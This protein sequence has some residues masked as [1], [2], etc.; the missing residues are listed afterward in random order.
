MAVIK[1]SKLIQTSPVLLPPTNL[2]DVRQMFSDNHTTLELYALG[3][4]GLTV[5]DAVTS[6]TLTEKLNVTGPGVLQFLA[7]G[8]GDNDNVVN[9]KFR[10][11]IDGVT[12][13]DVS[14][15]YTLNDT[16][17]LAAC[18]GF[19][20]GGSGLTDDQGIFFEKMP[21]NESLVVSVAGDGTDPV[22]LIYSYYLT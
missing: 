9:P 13:L 20:V 21:F 15:G 5:A 14:S 22:R 4:H 19:F 10:I 16:S 18:G 17:L 12:A 6:A 7:L 8:S 2:I 11:V 3:F 1:Y